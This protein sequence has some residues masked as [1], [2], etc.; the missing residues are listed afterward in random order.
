MR[1][2]IVRLVAAACLL[3]GLVGCPGGGGSVNTVAVTGTVTRG[4]KP[5]EGA[6]VS[7]VPQG[8]GRGLRS[9]RPT[10]PAGSP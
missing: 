2:S 9:E 4:G 8:Q 1:N 3:V 10:R 7:F 6:N 5:V